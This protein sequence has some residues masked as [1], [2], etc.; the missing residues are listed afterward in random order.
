MP[1]VPV[2]GTRLYYEE[3]GPSGGRPLLLLH[4][5]LQTGESMKPL[6]ELFEPKGFRVVMP[7]QRGHGR[8]A[9]PAR[10]L[11]VRQLADDVEALMAQLGLERPIIAGYSLGGIVG[12][13][14]ASRGLAG[15]LVIL[16]SRV[17][18]AAKG[19]KAF[20]PANIRERSPQ[21][22][23]QLEERHV[24]VYWEELA[25]ELG[26]LLEE[27]WPGFTPEELGAIRCPV[28]VVQGDKDLMVPVEQAH[29][30]AD[31]VP[32]AQLQIIPRAGHP[33][34][35]YRQDALNVVTDF[36]GSLS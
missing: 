2:H 31:L 27:T 33:E 14:L 9:N 26:L 12:M 4:A 19:R 20:A 22:V 8:T 5:A 21:W 10:S 34:L 17:Q 35:L 36:V 25:T 29:L 32:G 7:D 30:I 13:T 3:T 6:A 18:P 1:Y 24:E 11:S 23:K 15:G 16:A 28:L